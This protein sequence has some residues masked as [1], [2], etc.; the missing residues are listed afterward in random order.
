MGGVM[1]NLIDK[2]TT[3]PTKASQ[4]FST[5]EDNQAAV[6]VHVCQGERKMAAQNKSLGKFD[7]QDIPPAARGTPQIE[8]SFDIDAILMSQ[9]LQR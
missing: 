3:I 9:Q 8:V 2:N 7:L 6:T 5:A 1:T 4:V